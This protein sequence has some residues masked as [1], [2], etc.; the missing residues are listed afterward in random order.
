MSLAYA[1]DILRD[2][3]SGGRAD[4]RCRLVDARKVGEPSSCLSFRVRGTFIEFDTGS[5]SSSSH[6]KSEP[7][8]D[9]TWRTRFG[10]EQTNL[11]SVGPHGQSKPNTPVAFEVKQQTPNRSN[12]QAQDSGLPVCSPEVEQVNIGV[13]QFPH[14]ASHLRGSACSEP[15]GKLS[16]SDQ[17]GQVCIENTSRAALKLNSVAT[18]QQTCSDSQS[19]IL[20]GCSAMDIIQHQVGQSMYKVASCVVNNVQRRLETIIEFIVR[21]CDVAARTVISKLQAIPTM[22]H[23]FLEARIKSAKAEIHHRVQSMAWDPSGTLKGSFVGCERHGI[24]IRAISAEVKHEAREAVKR[25]ALECCAHAMQQFVSIVAI[26]K[27]PLRGKLVSAIGGEADVL[28]FNAALAQT[29]A[30]ELLID[31]Q[32]T[33]QTAAEPWPDPVFSAGTPTA[34]ARVRNGVVTQQLPLAEVLNQEQVPNPG[35]IGHPHLC[36]RVCIYFAMGACTNGQ[37]C[38]FCHMPHPERIMRLNRRNRAILEG[39][40]FSEL[41]ILL[42]PILKRKIL[43]LQAADEGGGNARVHQQHV[44]SMVDASQVKLGALLDSLLDLAVARDGPS[45][46]VACVAEAVAVQHSV[47]SGCC[48]GHIRSN[49]SHINFATRTDLNCR[50]RNDSLK[51]ALESMSIRNLLTTLQRVSPPDAEEERNIMALV[52]HDLWGHFPTDLANSEDAHF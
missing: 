34:K 52:F 31:G 47:C 38:G 1:C 32:C 9:F 12:L 25:A 36:R 17:G 16:S 28:G 24:E 30:L 3:G 45:Q 41:I 33:Q 42:V 44:D 18:P 37:D 10:E 48:N 35:S 23:N 2:S 8:A 27:Q 4:L 13:P 39:K 46:H 26:L 51:A 7:A 6:A 40:P 15:S 29:A 43:C 50:R 21:G 5:D 14:G 22:V 11:R 49:Q 19:V 20:E